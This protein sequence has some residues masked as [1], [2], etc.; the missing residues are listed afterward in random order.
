MPD[1]WPIQERMRQLKGDM[2]YR[3]LSEAIYQ[4]TGKRIGFTALSKLGSGERQ[5]GRPSTIAALAEYAGRP[6]SWFYEEDPAPM[7]DAVAEA[8]AKYMVD[9][10]DPEVEAVRRQALD[11]LARDGALTPEN[12]RTLATLLEMMAK[13]LSRVKDRQKP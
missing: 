4:R 5:L 8:K 3:E 13:D 2:T 12:L 10:G 7:P 6:I 1:R 9:S 11:Q